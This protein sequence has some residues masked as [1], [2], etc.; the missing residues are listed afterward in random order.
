MEL[1]RKTEP[2]AYANTTIA[3]IA[4]TAFA[5]TILPSSGATTKKPL[6]II[7]ANGVRVARHSGEFLIFGESKVNV[8]AMATIGKTQSIVDIVTECFS[9]FVNWLLLV[10][11]RA[12]LYQ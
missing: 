2:I 6:P 12:W 8:K 5:P 1:K 7:D 9:H 10:L 3:K 4:H 11:A